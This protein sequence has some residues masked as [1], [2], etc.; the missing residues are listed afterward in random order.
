MP[1]GYC[2]RRKACGNLLFSPHPPIASTP[3]KKGVTKTP[4]LLSRRSLVCARNETEGKRSEREVGTVSVATGGWVCLV[5]GPVIVLVEYAQLNP[6][7]PCPFRHIVLVGY[8]EPLLICHCE[9]LL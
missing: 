9:P 5:V 4:P 2:E 8:C 7:K 6:A 1:A 3:S